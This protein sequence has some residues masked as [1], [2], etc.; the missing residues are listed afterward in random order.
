MKISIL[1][2]TINPYFFSF[3]KN[4]LCRHVDKIIALVLV[5]TTEGIPK[6]RFQSLRM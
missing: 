6:S 1:P 2:I 4:T 3:N 5:D